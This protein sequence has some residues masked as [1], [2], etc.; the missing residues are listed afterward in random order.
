MSHDRSYFG[1]IEVL[2]FFVFALL[3]FWLRRH[4]LGWLGGR[5]LLFLLRWWLLDR[6]LRWLA[7]CE[8]WLIAWRLLLLS[9]DGCG[10][11]GR[12]YQ[13]EQWT[14]FHLRIPSLG[15]TANYTAKPS[16]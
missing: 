2:F 8:R 6:L 5:L 14:H 12:K 9:C 15:Q 16:C 3:G 1:H 10:Q 4:R 13:C 11:Q 7:L